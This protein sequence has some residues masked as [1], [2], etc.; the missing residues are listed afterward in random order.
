MNDIEEFNRCLEGAKELTVDIKELKRSCFEE[1][2]HGK[3]V[4][5]LCLKRLNREIY[6]L[7]TTRQN[8]RFAI[9]EN[10]DYVKD[11]FKEL[12]MSF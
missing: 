3:R 2:E 9:S 7:E 6:L 4:D 11:I 5:L 10:S 1:I 8:L 12:E